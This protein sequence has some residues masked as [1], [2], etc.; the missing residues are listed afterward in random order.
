MKTKLLTPADLTE[1]EHPAIILFRSLELKCTYENT[2]HID[3]KQ[4]S[5]DL[6]SGDGYLASLLFDEKFTYGIDNGEAQDYQI[7]IDKKRYGTVLLESAEKMSLKDNSLNFIFC[8]SV[9]EHIPGNE[10]V[11]S[12]VA[13]T[14]KKGG[15]FVFTSPSDKFKEYLYISDILQKTGLGFMAN[16]YKNKR[17]H[18]LNHYHTLSHKEWGKRL[19]KHN[20]EIIKYDYYISKE[21]CM[22]WDKLALETRIQGIFDRNAEKELYK[23][24]KEE[25]NYIYQHDVVAGE[26]GASLFI[27]AVKK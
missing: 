1:Y 6:G 5:T 16:W 14:L 19:K 20:L 22:L 17:Q 9:I 15:S 18:M 25:I 3:F 24:Y 26:E 12:E 2:K 11:L 8:N 10:A 4:P 23:E 13:R 7:A 21:A 27:H